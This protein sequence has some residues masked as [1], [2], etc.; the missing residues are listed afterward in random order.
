MKYWRADCSR[1]E[2][3]HQG[4]QGAPGHFGE[5]C[6]WD[7][8]LTQLLPQRDAAGQVGSVE[9]GALKD[10]LKVGGPAAAC[11]SYKDVKV[12]ASDKATSGRKV[13]VSV[14]FAA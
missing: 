12:L 14:D 2:R 10:V 1:D 13:D 8:I 7:G 11:F 5:G 4:T 9:L 3:R 6:G